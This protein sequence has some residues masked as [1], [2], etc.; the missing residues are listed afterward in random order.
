MKTVLHYYR[1]DVSNAAD[2]AAYAKL[3]AETLDRIGFPCHTVRADYPCYSVRKSAMDHIA[4][5]RD[6]AGPV[7]LETRHLFP[8][9]WNSAG[10][11]NARLF[12]WSEMVY[13]NRDI[14]EGYW[15]E[16]TA[17]MRA[18]LRDTLKCGYC[19]AQ[20]PAAGGLSFCPNCRDS[21]YLKVA[22]LRLTR[23]VPVRDDDKPRAELT[24]AERDILIP[25][26]NDAQI[27]GATERG[28]KRIAEQR[29]AVAVEYETTIA[30]AAEKRAAAV[31]IM[32]NAPGVYANWIFYT[33]TG[34]HTFGWRKPLSAGERRELMG[35]IDGFPFAYE[36][37]TDESE[38]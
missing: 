24:D 12:N 36:I 27:H 7:T 14:R 30:N 5:I 11:L 25:L 32:D 10:P 23:M 37:I 20:A 6:H 4:R 15:L 26:F 38:D 21:E 31:W 16:Q 17:A 29:R 22:D 34:K 8:D 33:H 1:F 18:A 35:V 13:A 9:Q 28:K 2:A 19:G 3:R